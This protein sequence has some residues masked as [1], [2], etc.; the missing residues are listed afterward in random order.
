M[1]LSIIIESA[2]T[3]GGRGA[4]A[5]GPAGPATLSSTP[6]RDV[7]QSL[8]TSTQLERQRSKPHSRFRS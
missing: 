5:W 6:D 3:R 2:R 8:V 4:G 1:E 7:C